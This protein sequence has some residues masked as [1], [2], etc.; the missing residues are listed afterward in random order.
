MTPSPI[1]PGVPFK[2]ALE[3]FPEQL[4]IFL[5]KKRLNLADMTMN[6]ILPEK[7]GSE[8]LGDVHIKSM[9]TSQRDF[10]HIN[11]KKQAQNNMVELK[12]RSIQSR[13]SSRKDSRQSLKKSW[14]PKS[15]SQQSS[16]KGKYL[17]VSSCLVYRLGGKP[18]IKIS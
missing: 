15:E 10:S 13:R 6:E 16:H 18:N 8:T 1:I 12:S 2:H 9:N 17:L 14:D 3:D 4:Q 11:S 7:Q 5:N